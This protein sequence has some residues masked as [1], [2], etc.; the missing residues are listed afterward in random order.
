MPS[1]DD[2]QLPNSAMLQQQSTAERRSTKP[3]AAGTEFFSE[4][5][6]LSHKALAK[7][8]FRVL[9]NILSVACRVAS[10]KPPKPAFVVGARSN[11]SAAVA[12]A[13]PCSHCTWHEH[14]SFNQSRSPKTMYA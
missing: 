14:V 8:K 3:L 6:E 4:F 7:L 1:T 12:A 13:Y 5:V 11:R 9:N 10:C 2:T